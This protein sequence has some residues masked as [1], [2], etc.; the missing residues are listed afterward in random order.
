MHIE[1]IYSFLLIDNVADLYLKKL[2]RGRKTAFCGIF[3]YK[4]EGCF[5]RTVKFLQDFE[6]SIP[7]VNGKPYESLKKQRKVRPVL[8]YADIIVWKG[9]EKTKK[10]NASVV[11]AIRVE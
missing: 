4:N 3:R 1:D 6:H 5:Y 9:N 10:D 8:N 7:R 2:L 11:G